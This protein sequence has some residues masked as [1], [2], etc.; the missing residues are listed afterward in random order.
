MSLSEKEFKRHDLIAKACKRPTKKNHV[1]RS[2]YDTS[3]GMR[4][5]GF[6]VYD[7]YDDFTPHFLGLADPVA[8]FLFPTVQEGCERYGRSH[9]WQAPGVGVE[10]PTPRTPQEWKWGP[11][12]VLI[13]PANK[14]VR[15]VG[16]AFQLTN[17]GVYIIPIPQINL[18][19]LTH[20]G[21]R[22]FRRYIATL[23]GKID[24]IQKVRTAGIIGSTITVPSAPATIVS[25]P[26]SQSIGAP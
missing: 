3:A 7:L 14:T 8:V 6:Q 10:T 20:L 2:F 16:S 12:H 21:D 24:M 13:T 15:Y 11:Q 19:V 5:I 17:P 22:E 23:E 26:S 1:R 4:Q 18:T 25:A 9:V